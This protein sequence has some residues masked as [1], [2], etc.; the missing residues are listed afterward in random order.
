MTPGFALYQRFQRGTAG[1]S[2]RAGFGKS[3]TRPFL[4]FA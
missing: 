3:K 1:K 2:K 4:V